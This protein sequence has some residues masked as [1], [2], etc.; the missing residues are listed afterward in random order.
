[1][2]VLEDTEE[3]DSFELSE[4]VVESLEAVEEEL[5][6]L[7]VVVVSALEEDELVMILLPQAVSMV[8]PNIRAATDLVFLYITKAPLVTLEE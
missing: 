8:T 5:D 3:D 7:E 1:V 4:L 6:T 2:V